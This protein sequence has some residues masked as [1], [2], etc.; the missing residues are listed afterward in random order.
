MKHAAVPAIGVSA[1]GA[2]DR[3]TPQNASWSFVQGVLRA[4]EPKLAVLLAAVVFGMSSAPEIFSNQVPDHQHLGGEYFNIARALTEGRGF[5]DPFALGTGPTAWMPPLFPALLAGLLL[6]L[7]QKSAV[8]TAVVVLS[9]SA[10]VASGMAL[11]RVAAQHRRWLSPWFAAALY[12]AWLWA[13]YDS[14]FLVTHDI[15]LLSLVASAMLLSLSSQLAAHRVQPWRWGAL[16]GIAALSSPTLAFAWCGVTLLFLLRMHGQRRSTLCALLL[17]VAVFAP[18]FARNARVFHSVT[19]KSN[20]VFEAYQAN[21]MDDDGI[22]DMRVLTTHPYNS[23]A[24]RNEYARLGETRFLARYREKLVAS[25]R[26]DPGQYFRHVAN[27]AIAATLREVPFVPEQLD[28][29]RRFERILYPLPL[30]GLLFALCL[31]G[32]RDRFLLAAACLYALYLLPYVSIA[33]YIRYFLV[34]TPILVL[35]VFLGFDAIGLLLE[36]R[37]ASVCAELRPSG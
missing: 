30:L 31:R 20:V 13:F 33:F 17:A 19:A 24:A 35:F 7:K 36:R 5:S 3:V 22:Y 32:R 1:S 27:R 28:G 26:R 4:P 37:R 34:L 25:L 15:W 8:A 14:L 21:Y 6:L 23:P 16:G 18:W 12:V 10:F 9:N 11:F 29:T 2:A